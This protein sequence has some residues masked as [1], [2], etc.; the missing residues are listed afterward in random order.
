M[1]PNDYTVMLDPGHGFSAKKKLYGRPLMELKNNKVSV[2]SATLKEDARDHMPG[3]YR[4]DHGTFLIAIAATKALSDLGYKV[5]STR[6]DRLSPSHNLPDKLNASKWKRA[7][8]KGWQWVKEATKEYKADAF[9]SIHTNGGGGTGIAGLYANSGAGKSMAKAICTE[10]SEEFGLNI[11]RIARHR[12][13]ILRN[14]CHGNACL[15]ECAFHDHPH[16]LSLLLSEGGLDK[17]G[18]AIARGVDIHL[19]SLNM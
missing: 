15:I 7:H 1:K 18:Q 11:R 8:W 16:D 3:F 6:S 5:Y 17:F 4:E 13:L 12:Y 2:A 19:K 9:V 10:I 14:I